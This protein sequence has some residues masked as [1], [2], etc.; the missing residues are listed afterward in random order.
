MQ[1][2]ASAEQ[3]D[4]LVQ[5][6]QRDPEVALRMVSMGWASSLM[7][8]KKAGVVASRNRRRCRIVELIVGIS[9][10]RLGVSLPG[11]SEGS[12]GRSAGWVMDLR[13]RDIAAQADINMSRID[14]LRLFEVA[15]AGLRH[16]S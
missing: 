3:L 1:D 8:L 10:C 16:G 14:A 2:A 13:I 4:G 9:E 7:A 15:F 12:A 11:T 6:L 5:R